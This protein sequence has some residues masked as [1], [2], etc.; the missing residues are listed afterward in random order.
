VDPVN[1]A[2]NTLLIRLGF[3]REGTLRERWITRD[4]AYDTHIYG[5]LSKEWPV[6]ERQAP[7]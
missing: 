6:P 2:S 7:A 5:I 1:Q 4:A 3:T